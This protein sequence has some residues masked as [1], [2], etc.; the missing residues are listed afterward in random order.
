MT[1]S[2][3]TRTASRLIPLY[4][5][6]YLH[7][8]DM[9]A[10]WP[11]H[12]ATPLPSEPKIAA[13]FGVSR[14]TVRATLAQLEKEGMVRRVHGVGTFP[15][16][17]DMS[18]RTNIQGQLESLISFEDATTVQ[19]IACHASVAPTASA[20]MALGPE[21]CLKVVRLRSYRGQPVSFTIIS[22][23][24]AFA[25]L[26]SLPP[27]GN[28]PLIRTLER[29]GIVAT[30]AEQVLTAIAAPDEAA[31]H[32]A[33]LP[34]TPLIAMRRLMLDHA[35]V[36]VLHQE[37]LYVPDRFEYRMTLSRTNIGGI[38]KWTPTG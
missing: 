14:V 24:A 35:R 13:Q 30:S 6:V 20:A 17:P 5:Q 7:L 29:H 28:A 26:I 34:G 23:P 4:H 1:M 15:I 10:A 31:H 16:R 9:I 3:K 8:K 22:V 38:A 32:L 36:P 33:V 21:P 27:E 19:N 37:S 2:G 11:E 25:H 18:E 12:A